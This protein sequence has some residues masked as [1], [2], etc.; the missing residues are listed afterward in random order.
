MKGIALRERTSEKDAYDLYMLARYYKEGP[1]SVLEELSLLK[2]N[3]L[4]QEAMRNIEESFKKIDS[5]GT[6]SIIVFIGET[7]NEGRIR[8]QRDVYEVIRFIVE[9]MKTMQ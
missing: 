2:H 4:M 9:G 1:K 7:D 6:V 5:I 3:K 8:L